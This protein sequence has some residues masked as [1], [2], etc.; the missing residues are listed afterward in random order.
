MALLGTR[1]TMEQSFFKNKLAQKQIEV[2]V[3]G[4]ND[5]QFLHNAIFEEL[6]KGIFTKETKGHF[7]SIINSLIAQ[8]AEG[9][10]LGCTEFPLLIKQEDCSVPTFDTTI[11]HAN[12]AVKFALG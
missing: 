9:V 10:I 1:I 7:I 3:P 2:L 8:G 11:I 4:E 12:A 6:G 5:R